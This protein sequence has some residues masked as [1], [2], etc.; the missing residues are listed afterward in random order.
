VVRKIRQKSIVPWVRRAFAVSVR[1]AC[2]LLD[3]NRKSFYHVRLRKDDLILRQRIKEIAN[4]RVRYGYRRIQVLLQREGWRVNHKRVRRIY[5]EEGLS[6]R[7]R[8]P[9]RRR[10]AVVRS[11]RPIAAAAN[12][13]WSMDFMHDVLSDGRKIRLLTIV[14]NFTRENVALEVDFG[15]KAAQVVEV[16]RR[17]SAERQVPQR[18]RVDNGPEFVS[19]QLDQWAYWNKVEL[20]FSRPGK[21]T[22]NAFIESFNNRVRQELLNPNWFSSLFD[23]QARAAA[24][25]QDYNANHPHSSLGNLSP[26][27][28]AKI[29]R[30]RTTVAGKFTERTA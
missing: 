22:D 5:R 14:D 16:L 28:F 2:A 9:K 21:P 12:E 17:V 26:A 18:I 13:S 11:E 10:S 30:R 1:H 8:P 24:W 4:L 15:F 20:D 3:V 19:K 7:L 29:A 6:M 23:A 25:R 27:A